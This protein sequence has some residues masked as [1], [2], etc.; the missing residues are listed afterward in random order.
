MP[1]N[2]TGLPAAGPQT[3]P[4][5]PASGRRLKRALAW[6]AAVV[7][8]TPLVYLGG[9]AVAAALWP[10]SAAWLGH[11][12]LTGEWVGPYTTGDGRPH[13][14]YLELRLAASPDADGNLKGTARFCS[15]PAADEYRLRGRTADRRASRFTLDLGEG[16]DFIES[17]TKPVGEWS[18]ETIVLHYQPPR[19][20]DQGNPLNPPPAPPIRLTRG[21]AGQFASICR[22]LLRR[23][24]R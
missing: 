24:P 16:P 10:W 20:D 8:A 17:G 18:G 11:P 1:D 13:A 15:G 3:P 6:A 19:Y 5:P 14:A 12:T 23:P 21:N 22:G 2:D 4:S 9:K 7:V